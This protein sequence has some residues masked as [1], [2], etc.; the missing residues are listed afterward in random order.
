MKQKNNDY[1]NRVSICLDIIKKNNLDAKMFMFN[2]MGIAHISSKY[3][4]LAKNQFVEILFF[5][6][7]DIFEVCENR[8]SGDFT[9]YYVNSKDYKNFR[10][11][12]S[13]YINRT[14]KHL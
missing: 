10:A 7:D 9:E 14:F 5:D 3:I 2:D 12:F 4:N 8:G 1:K 6:G 11:A 13:N